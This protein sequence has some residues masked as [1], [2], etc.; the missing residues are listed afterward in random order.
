[1]ETKN[2]TAIGLSEH[3]KIWNLK[4]EASDNTIHYIQLATRPMQSDHKKRVMENVEQLKKKQRKLSATLRQVTERIQKL[5]AELFDDT[6]V[7][8]NVS[9]TEVLNDEKYEERVATPTGEVTTPPSTR[10]PSTWS[11][12]TW[13]FDEEIEMADQEGGVCFKC[14]GPCQLLSQACGSCMRR[15]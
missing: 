10:S 4:T 13:C 8:H 7:E 15:L 12:S 6:D 3:L 1:M 5:E 2:E 9:G 14:G 11:P